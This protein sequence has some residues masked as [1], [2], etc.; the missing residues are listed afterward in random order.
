MD[1]ADF[2]FAELAEV[3]EAERVEIHGGEGLDRFY[4]EEV[5]KRHLRF[6]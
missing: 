4:V 3:G 1:E 5:R 6:W 2:G